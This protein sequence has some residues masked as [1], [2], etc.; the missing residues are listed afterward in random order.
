MRNITI[1]QNDL[2]SA[3]TSLQDYNSQKLIQYKIKLLSQNQDIPFT[4]FKPLDLITFSWILAKSEFKF[5]D[6]YYKLCSELSQKLSTLKFKNY[7]TLLWS[8]SKLQLYHS[9]LI[10]KLMEKV[11]ENEKDLETLEKSYL[12][13]LYIFFLCY[14]LN[15]GKNPLNQN[16][17]SRI[18]SNHD[19]QLYKLLERKVNLNSKINGHDVF[20][21]LQY[22][23][24]NYSKDRNVVLNSIAK[25]IDQN[26]N[27]GLLD[28]FL[29]TFMLSRC[30]KNELKS[31]I[32]NSLNDI[33][34]PNIDTTAIDELAS[35]T[36]FDKEIKTRFYSVL[37]KCIINNYKVY[38]YQI[39]T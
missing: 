37:E 10:E 20:I 1:F 27:I 35:F 5:T 24:C 19:V 23:I 7:C 13:N 36:S 33:N 28:Q 38:I 29:G 34:E 3:S 39:L 32:K 31:R 2:S 15:F 18:T 16:N 25:H 21:Y 30:K 4:K 17:P 12:A 11:F 6:L 9:V 22:L 26:I 8:A 14:E